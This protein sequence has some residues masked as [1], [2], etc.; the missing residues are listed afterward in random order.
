MFDFLNLRQNI[1]HQLIRAGELV[2]PEARQRLLSHGIRFRNPFSA[3]HIGTRNGRRKILG[4]H[5]GWNDVTIVGKNHLLDVVFGKGTPVTQVD[6]WYIGLV[7]NSP[8]PVFAEADTLASHS[9][10]A[11]FSSYSGNR[12][13]WDDADSANKIK[14]TT[15]VSTFTMSG[16]GTING[17]FIASVDT[18]T[19]GILWAT[20]SFDTIVTVVSSDELKVTYGIRC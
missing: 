2:A 9:G 14:G 20:G 13:A 16:S 12:K 8:S 5:N 1:S 6:P 7:N 19:S 10:W 17:I 3:V 15:T 4:V 11:E 18:G